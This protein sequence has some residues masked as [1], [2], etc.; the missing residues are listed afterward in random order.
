MDVIAQSIK[1]LMEMAIDYRLLPYTL[2]ASYLIALALG[3]RTGRWFSGF[4]FGL[5]APFALSW[6]LL[7]GSAIVRHDWIGDPWLNLG[8][9]RRA[10][11]G[12]V[13]TFTLFTVCT[14][15]SSRSLWTE[16]HIGARVFVALALSCAHALNIVA[17]G[18]VIWASEED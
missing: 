2:F 4:M 13:L 3:A 16:T 8:W 17:V 11:V 14:W 12:C 6:L 1:F 9:S 15:I 18:V 10:I 7:T 5:S